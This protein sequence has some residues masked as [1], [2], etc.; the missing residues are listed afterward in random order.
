VLELRLNAPRV[1]LCTRSLRL[2]RSALLSS[3]TTCQN[4]DNPKYLLKFWEGIGLLLCSVSRSAWVA[5]HIAGNEVPRECVH[6][7]PCFSVCRAIHLRYPPECDLFQILAKILGGNWFIA[8]WCFSVCL[9]WLAYFWDC[10]DAGICVGGSS[11]PW[12]LTNV[13]KSES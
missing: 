2:A 9:D 3:N 8:L 10:K 4:T 1:L 5:C 11:W 13:M 6:G 12:W 7:A